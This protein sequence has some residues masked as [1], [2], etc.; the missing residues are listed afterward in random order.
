MSLIPTLRKQKQVDLY[1]TK[2][3]PKTVSDTYWDPVSKNKS[4]LK[5]ALHL[6]KSLST[7]KW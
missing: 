7:H 6:K 3:S 2:V 4:N 5:A 1:E